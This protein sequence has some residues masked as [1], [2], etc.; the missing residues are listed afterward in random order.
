MAWALW[1]WLAAA[2]VW[3][4]VENK[5]KTPVWKSIWLWLSGVWWVA[6]VL[7]GVSLLGLESVL[8]VLFAWLWI[9]LW[10][11][12]LYFLLTGKLNKAKEI[13]KD[14]LW[15]DKTEEII[16]KIQE[17]ITQEWEKTTIR[18]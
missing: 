15:E 11:L 16:W 6:T 14:K 2:S 17:K 9:S 3:A 1:W 18:V 7:S 13:S 8:G 12:F 4:L 10:Y 5:A